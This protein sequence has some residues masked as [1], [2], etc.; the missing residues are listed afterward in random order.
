LF[1]ALTGM[2]LVTFQVAK[3]VWS[4]SQRFSMPPLQRQFRR[5]Y[6]FNCN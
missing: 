2:W 4:F 1:F 6:Q 5:R 3:R